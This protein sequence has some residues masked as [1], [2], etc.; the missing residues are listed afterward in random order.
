MFDVHFNT[1]IE[2]QARERQ[3]R[4]GLYLK[5]LA[6]AAWEPPPLGSVQVQLISAGRA[7]TP[8]IFILRSARPETKGSSRKYPLGRR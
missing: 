2:F 7:P 1:K 5:L 8:A 3:D 4:L 6:P